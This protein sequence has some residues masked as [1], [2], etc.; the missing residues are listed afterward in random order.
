MKKIF[1]LMLALCLMV[2]VAAAE[3]VDFSQL[4]ADLQENG[5]E[6]AMTT[7]DSLGMQIYLP[8]G[9]VEDPDATADEGA[10][11]LYAWKAADEESK[12]FIKISY[13][14][15]EL[16]DVQSLLD[17]AVAGGAA[18]AKIVDLPCGWQVVVATNASDDTVGAGL[19]CGDGTVVSIDMGPVTGQEEA[20][21]YVFGLIIA[22]LSP[23]Q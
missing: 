1:A 20:I 16:T 8:A 12:D 7:L 19:L 14:S 6:G 18:D 11:L 2:G 22:T 4:V 15:T 13:A 9:L 17:V 10:T 3:T 23:A 21:S 5:V